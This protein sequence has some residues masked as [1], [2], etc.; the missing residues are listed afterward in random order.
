MRVNPHFLFGLASLATLCSV[1]AEY[2]KPSPE[3]AFSDYKIYDVAGRPWR[4][5]RE[6]WDGAK[7]RV[8]HD[9][10]WASWL[11]KQREAVDHWRAK[12]RDRA[13]WAAGWSHDGVSPK[14]AS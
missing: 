12:P 14:D 6:D 8:A 2:L 11:K 9:P 1:R 13:E 5:A 7:Q 4:A 3:K 10:E